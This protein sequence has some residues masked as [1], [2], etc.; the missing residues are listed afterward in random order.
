MHGTTEVD[1]PCKHGHVSKFNSLVHFLHV[2][3]HICFYLL[4]L[5]YLVN[6]HPMIQPNKQGINRIN[7]RMPNKSWRIVVLFRDL[8]P[9]IKRQAIHHRDICGN[10][11]TND[12]IMNAC[13]CKH[14][15]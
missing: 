12:I 4:K 5:L 13:K 8:Q 9:N 1:I 15:E 6:K 2:H 7:L 11:D 14:I 3:I 10:D